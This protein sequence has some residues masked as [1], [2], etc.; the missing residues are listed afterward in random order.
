MAK[1]KKDRK[2]PTQEEWNELLSI[3]QQCLPL[4]YANI[5]SNKLSTQE[6]QVSILTCL[7]MDNTEMSI[8]LNSTSKAICNAKQKANKKMFNN[9]SASSL[10][11][12]LMKF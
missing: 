1:P 8:I 2:S 11:T 7:G 4:P 3:F 6:F 12:N 10:Y 5:S 9:N